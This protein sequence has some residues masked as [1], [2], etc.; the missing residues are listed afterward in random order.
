MCSNEAQ[1]FSVGTPCSTVFIHCCCSFCW[2]SRWRHWI[3]VACSRQTV[4]TQSRQ[5]STASMAATFARLIEQSIPR[6]RETK[7]LGPDKNITTGIRTTVQALPSQEAGEPW[8]VEALQDSPRRSRE[9]LD[10]QIED[11]R[12]VKDGRLGFTLGIK[13]KFDLWARVK[14]YE[15]GVHLIALE[16]VGDAA[17]DLAIDCEIG[18]GCK[19]RQEAGVGLDL[20]RRRSTR[21]HRLPFA[22]RQQRQRTHHPG[23]GR[24][25]ST[26]YKGPSSWRS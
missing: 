3:A 16:I 4:A 7:R 24:G 10:V 20:A 18:S 14:V 13:A 8:H 5:A 2:S 15:Y 12:A 26:S 23:T 25:V 1:T 21:H 19:R 9:T 22:P 17:I 6:V 11:L